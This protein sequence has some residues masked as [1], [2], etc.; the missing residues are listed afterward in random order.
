M[1]ELP[2]NTRATVIPCVTYDD[3][4][5]AIEWLCDH[6]GFTTH[7]VYE[8]NEG[9]VMHAELSFGNGMLMLGSS[10]KKSDYGKVM[11]LPNEIGGRQTQTICVITNDPDEIY[12]RAKAGG[13]EIFLDIEDKPYG[14][15]GFSCRDLEGHIWSFGDYDPWAA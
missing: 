3:A 7:S 8:D 5:A 14:G 11:A 9:R 15:R 10:D 12:R 6:F 2:K 13:A 1:K 4:P